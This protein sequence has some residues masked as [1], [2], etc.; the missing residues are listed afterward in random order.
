ML[1]V[2]RHAGVRLVIP[3]INVDA[4]AVWGSTGTVEF[5]LRRSLGLRGQEVDFFTV[6]RCKLDP[7]LK[8]PGFKGST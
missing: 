2:A 5:W 1:H 3:F 6:R 8:A 4:I 7:N